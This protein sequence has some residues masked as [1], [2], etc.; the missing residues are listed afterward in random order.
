MVFGNMGETSRHR[1]RLHP[2][3]RRPASAAYYGEYLIN[4][5]GEDV[6]AGI[7]TPQYLTRAA[8]EQS[9]GDGAVDGRDDAG[10]LRRAR[11]ASSTCSSAII[12]TCRTSSSP[13]SAALCGCCRRAPASAPPRRLC[14]SPSTWRDEG[15]IAEEEAVLRVDPPALDQL[16]HPTLDPAAAREVIAKGLPASP[17]A[18]CGKAVF[19]ADTAEKRAGRRRKGDPG[20]DRDQ[21]RGHSRHARRAGHP[22]RARR[23]DQPRRGGRAR[24]GPALRVAAPARSR[25]TIKA[26][27]MRVGGPRGARRRCHH[28]RRLDRRGDARRGAD[29]PARAGRRFR[30]ADG[31]GRHQAPP[32]GPRQ[33]RD[34]R[35]TAAPRASSAPRGSAC[36][37]PSICSSTPS[38]SPTSA[39]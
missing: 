32:P 27:L 26:R 4:A 25:S 12:A 16:L 39:R 1:R 23:H 31:L 28:P 20:P 33:C 30:H 36:A 38:G 37:A 19:D 3:S 35:S 22:H 17:G 6:V 18:A 8:R 5:Q 9:R 7:R 24:H 14:A 29:R 34:A 2:R 15:L 13:S 11:R 21:P 10:S